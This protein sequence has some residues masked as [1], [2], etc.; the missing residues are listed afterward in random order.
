M[1]RCRKW[2]PRSESGNGQK[3]KGERVGVMRIE[4]V[5]QER[6]REREERE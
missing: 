5:K 3:G 2:S 1:E 4:G 6:E